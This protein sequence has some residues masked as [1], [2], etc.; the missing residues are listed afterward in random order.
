MTR[1]QR[2]LGWFGILVVLAIAAAGG[3]YAYKAIS[4]SD[5]APSCLAAQSA[6][7]QK[8][9]RTETEAAAAQ[10]CQQTCQRETQA[11]AGTGR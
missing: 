11:C 9:R 2:G 1:R 4:E 6:C 3:Y 8:C 10:S 5:E 7:L